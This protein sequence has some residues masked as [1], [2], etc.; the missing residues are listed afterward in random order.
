MR[1]IL[2]EYVKMIQ[3]LENRR[4]LSLS[5]A[6]EGTVLVVQGDKSANIISVDQS[7][8]SL[9]VTLDDSSF[10]TPLRKVKSIKVMGMEGNDILTLTPNVT[11]PAT[12][13]GGNGN[14]LLIGSD[15]ACTLSGD[16]GND[17]LR[18]GTGKDVL[19][20]GPGADVADYSGRTEA[21]SLT[22][23][24][25]ANDGHRLGPGVAAE[26]DNIGNDIEILK[27]GSGNDKLSGN[28]MANT[29]LG[30][31]GNDL[32]YGM[33]G[34]DV[35][36]GGSGNDLLSGGAGDDVLLGGDLAGGDT[37]DGGDGNDAYVIDSAQGVLDTLVNCEVELSVIAT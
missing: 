10:T 16:A 2:A 6:V 4:M 30:G 29:L 34:N 11:L 18:P 37:L 32:L 24:G 17:V 3:P 9:V 35:L 33:A 13:F 22:L 1:G 31:G 25:K 27:G 36:S 20:G 26:N 19:N 7:A 28:A 15:R 12:L 21:L 23:D 8:T 5:V 14:D